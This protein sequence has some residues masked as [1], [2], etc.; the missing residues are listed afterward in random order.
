[1]QKQFIRCDPKKCICFKKI[2]LVVRLKQTFQRRNPQMQAM[3][4]VVPLDTNI[5]ITPVARV[6]K[7]KNYPGTDSHRDYN[8]QR[9]RV[10]C[11][12]A[13]CWD[14]NKQNHTKP[15]DIVGFRKKDNCVEL[16]RVVAVH[17]PSHHVSV[18]SFS[19][20]SW[21][22]NAFRKDQSGRNVL[23]LSCT[24]CIVPWCEWVKFG[25]HASGPLLGTHRVAN[26]QS[27]VRMI[28]YINAAIQNGP[29]V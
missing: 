27:R 15:N 9:K 13:M 14:D 17:D 10:L 26:E 25:W 12:Q 19:A 4:H 6:A 5:L 3:K 24:I 8:E 23:I 22:T 21:S 7:P 28:Q 16:H 2:E 20:R 1:M 11:G 29:D 18:D